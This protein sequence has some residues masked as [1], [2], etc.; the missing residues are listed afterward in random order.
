MEGVRD[1]MKHYERECIVL[2]SQY[3]N[4]YIMLE[5]LKMEYGSINMEQMEYFGGQITK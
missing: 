1:S 2:F 3:R 4:D 5:R